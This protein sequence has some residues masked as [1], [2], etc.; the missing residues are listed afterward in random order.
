MFDK[1]KQLLNKNEYPWYKYYGDMPRKLKYFDGSLYDYM[2]N[3]A[4]KYP[5]Y[6]ALEYFNKKMTYESFI[7]EINCVSH[8]LV[9]DGIKENDIVTI[10]MANTPEAII[11]FYAINKIGAISNI[12]HPLSSEVEIKGF[13]NNTQSKYVFISD[14]LYDTFVSINKDMKL[15]KVIVCPI[16]NKMDSI[17]KVIYNLFKAPKIKD[18]GKNFIFYNDYLDYDI[19]ECK[20]VKRKYNDDA[21][22][23]YSGG[24]TGKPKGVVLSNLSFNS[25]SLQ[26]TY[27]ITA[28]PG[29][30]ILSYLPIF[31]GFGLG[32]AI[33]TPLTYGMKCVVDPKLNIKKINNILKNKKVNFLPVIP[34]LLSAMCKDKAIGKKDLSNL[35][36]VLCGGDFLDWNLK[37]KSEKFLKRHGSKAQIVIGYGLTEATA[38]IIATI[39]NTCK[40]K[41]IGIPTPDTRYKVVKND[42]HITCEKNEVGEICV[43]GPSLMTRY[44]NDEE[45]TFKALQLHEDGVVWLHTGDL[46]YVGEDDILYFETRKKRVIISNGLNVYPGYIEEVLN[47]H[48]Y[49]EMSVVVGTKDNVRGQIVKA[50]VVLKDEIELTDEVKIE[51]KKYVR[52]RVSKYA[53]PRIYKFTKELPKTKI[54]KV[55]FKALQ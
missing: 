8:S 28:H 16:S 53:V 31:H 37:I 11:A 42:T 9:N 45:E 23:L 6:Y 49:V 1:I 55:D 29:D 15:D 35:K 25:L 48:P 27:V 17:H 39:G 51:I 30:V 38:A 22:I 21:V 12:I 10:C 50:I 41:S 3:T 52:K 4:L 36:Y 14:M 47:S 18:L 43:S 13:L 26:Y 44:Y 46:G 5:K 54:G 34:A 2:H 19:E 20:T 32:V 7:S 24:T 40:R 33:H